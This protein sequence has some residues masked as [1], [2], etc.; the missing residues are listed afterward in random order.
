MTVFCFPLQRYLFNQLFL[1]VPVIIKTSI[2]GYFVRTKKEN[3][4]KI[5]D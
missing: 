4:A 5:W 2:F 1:Q 3:H